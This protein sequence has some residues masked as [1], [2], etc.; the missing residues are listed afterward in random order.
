MTGAPRYGPRDSA[1]VLM[2][3]GR[4]VAL[5]RPRGGDPTVTVRMTDGT[6]RRMTWMVDGTPHSQAQLDLAAAMAASAARAETLATGPARRG[7]RPPA[8][9]ARDGR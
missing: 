6:T 9:P 7:H 2:S 1:S 5:R 3:L 4:T 8:R